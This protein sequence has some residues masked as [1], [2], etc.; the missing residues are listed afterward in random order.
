MENKL[1]P[2]QEKKIYG[3]VRKKDFEK[4]PNYLQPFEKIIVDTFIN[5]NAELSYKEEFLL[6]SSLGMLN[7]HNEMAN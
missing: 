2:R 5:S 7:L 3:Y 1:S 6:N 4:V